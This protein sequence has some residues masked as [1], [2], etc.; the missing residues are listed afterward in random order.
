MSDS[1]RRIAGRFQRQA[2]VNRLV[3]LA[4]MAASDF[5]EGMEKVTAAVR[6]LSLIE[7][8]AKELNHPDLAMEAAA[9]VGY[10]QGSQFKYSKLRGVAM[11]FDDLATKTKAKIGE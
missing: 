3:P 10:I 2:A 7:K 1:T 4:E 9:T 5:R 6:M 11:M 8:E